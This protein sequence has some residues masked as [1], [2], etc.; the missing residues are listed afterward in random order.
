MTDLIKIA[1]VTGGSRGLGRNTA[2]N[3]ARRGFDVILTYRS[4]KDEAERVVSLIEAAGRRAI[5]LQLDTGNSASFDSFIKTLQ[6]ALAKLGAEGIDALVNNAGNSSGMSF[7]NAQEDEF[8]ALYRIHVKVCFPHSKACA[9]DQGWWSHRECLIGP[10]EDH[11]GEPRRLRHD[12][13][14]CRND[15]QIYGVRAGRATHRRELRCARRYC[16]RFQRGCRAR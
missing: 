4:N 9:P 16:N 12:E 1:L 14:C 13:G 2:E 6:S 8:D 3:L 5:A 10:D 7:L 15:D 11:H